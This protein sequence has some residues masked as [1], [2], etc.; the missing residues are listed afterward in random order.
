MALFPANSED[1]NTAF[2]YGKG[3]YTTVTIK[4]MVVGNSNG[5][6][7]YSINSNAVLAKNVTNVTLDN[8]IEGSGSAVDGT[9]L[10]LTNPKLSI[11]NGFIAFDASETGLAAN[12][13]GYGYIRVSFT[14]S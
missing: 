12:S 3:S 4:G 10:T 6:K 9:A 14:L 1:N 2:C 8:F 7:A 5:T 13:V 11:E